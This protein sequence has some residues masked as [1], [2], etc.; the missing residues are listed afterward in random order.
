MGT[1]IKGSGSYIP[2]NEVTNTSFSENPFFMEDGKRVPGDNTTVINKFEEITGIQSRRYV[3]EDELNSK[4][5]F[6]AAHKAILNA[7]IDP[8]TIDSIVVA[9]NF[10]DVITGTNQTDIMPSIAARVK[11]HLGI[12]NPNCVAHDIIFGCPGWLQAMIHAHMFISGGFYKRCLIIGSEVLSRVLDPYDRDTMIFADGAG[13]TVLEHHDSDKGVLAFGALS[14]TEDELNYL[15]MGPSFN[16][17]NDN[18][19][20][21]VKM[22]GR[23]IY[24][25]ALSQVPAAMKDCL[26]K[27]GK[28]IDDL[29]KILIHQANE[30]MDE[31]IIKRFYRAYGIK[32]VPEDIMPMTI[33]RLGNSSVA[34]IP[35]L[36]DLIIRGELEGH[37]ISSGDCLMFASVGAGMNI[38]ALVYQV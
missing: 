15:G 29:S 24:E 21:Y 2:S 4:I 22:Q 18:T 36:Y 28:S 25:Y 12:K 10:G 6:I 37:T 5:A 27:S 33:A 34:T 9:H 7:D 35:T 30:K 8:E 16:R 3:S 38:N 11:H 13:A 17:F 19:T 26:D 31:A 1:I 14:H 23:K 20:R 32:D